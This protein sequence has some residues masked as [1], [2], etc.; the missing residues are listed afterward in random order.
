MQFDAFLSL[1]SWS[2]NYCGG[3][4]YDA[5][6]AGDGMWHYRDF[7]TRK[8]VRFSYQERVVVIRENQVWPSTSGR[9]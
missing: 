4:F 7:S 2:V 5:R 3:V 9:G 1:P 8:I 6:R